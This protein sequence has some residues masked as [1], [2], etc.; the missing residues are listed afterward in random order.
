MHS[1]VCYYTFP[2][3]EQNITI[4]YIFIYIFFKRKTLYFYVSMLQNIIFFI[5]C[6]CCCCLCC[7]CF[8]STCKCWIQRVQETTR[9]NIIK[10]TLCLDIATH[11]LSC[12]SLPQWYIQRYI[13]KVFQ[14]CCSSVC[15][16]NTQHSFIY[17]LIFN[18]SLF[19]LLL[20]LLLLL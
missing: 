20:L 5:L 16:L 13:H 10:R 15:L 8:F 18:V 7:L 12:Y 14:L 4:Y 17:H 6:C 19:F 11:I 3:T 1:F 9:T 2:L